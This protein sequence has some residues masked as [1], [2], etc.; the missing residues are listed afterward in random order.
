VQESVAQKIQEDVLKMVLEFVS[1]PPPPTHTH[2]HEDSAAGVD[3]DWKHTQI[4]EETCNHMKY[5]ATVPH[6]YAFH[7]FKYLFGHEY[8]DGM[9]VW[10]S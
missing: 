10:L 4:F 2:T 5:C 1:L 3:R 7:L 6:I 9:Q 8:I